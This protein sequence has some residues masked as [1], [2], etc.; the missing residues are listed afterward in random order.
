MIPEHVSKSLY[1]SI[2]CFRDICIQLQVSSSE[3]PWTLISCKIVCDHSSVSSM[4][5]IDSKRHGPED[6]MLLK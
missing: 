5:F 6:H 4:Y 1:F 2:F 3:W